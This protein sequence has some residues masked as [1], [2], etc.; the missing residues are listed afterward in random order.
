MA[1]PATYRPAP[2]SIPTGPGVYRFS[3]ADG[4]VLYV[5]KAKNLRQRLNSYFAD[6][7]G[8]HFRTQTMVRTAA[9]VEWTVV[10]NELESLQL[11]YTWIK[12]F[13]PRFN[14]KY[15]DDKSY[16]WVAVTWS[17]DFPRVF[18]GR[19][20]RRRGTR[21]FGPYAHAWAIRDTIDS[22]LRV[23]PMRSCTGGVF[24]GA[25]AA[26]RPC[27]LGYIGKCSAPCV[28]RI[29][30]D[31]HRLLVEDLCAFLA[32]NTGG[33][34]RRLER[35]MAAASAALEFERAAVLRDQLG[36]LR[37]VAERNAIVLGDGTDADVISYAADELEI[38]FQIFH[39]RGGRVRG[40]RGWVADR[41]DDQTIPELLDSF[42]LELYADT[43]DSTEVG[44]AIPREVLLPVRPASADALAALL[45]DV[46]GARVDLR[47]PKRGD[48]R[49]L[50][51]TVA[52][53]AADALALHKTRRASDLSTRNRALEEIQEAL[54]LPT[55]PL[56]LECYDISHL[57]GT[58]VVGSM[59]VFEDGLPRKSEYRSFLIRTVEGSNDVGALHEVLTR[60]FRR[61]LEDRAAAQGEQAML[62]DP[63]TGVARRFA[64]APGLVV[65][66]GGA[67]QVA[68]AQAALD[69]LGITGVALVGLA[70]RLEE[71]WLPGEEFPVIMPRSSEG[72]FL[73][74]RARDEAHRFAITRHRSRRSRS[75]V[76]SLLDDVPGLGELRRKALLKHFGSLKK[77]RAARWEDIAQ[78]PGIGPKTALAIKAALDAQAPAEALDAA[79]GELV[80]AD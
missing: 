60:R 64:Y 79:T 56:R 8:L 14:I 52:A 34:V 51:D 42:L 46:R 48:K 70:K 66:D 69:A 3:D 27:L 6:P 75:M 65:V 21:Y 30:E 80:P 1:D 7:A 5:G 58:E 41:I 19:G 36:A 74:Q 68:A 22:L 54:G 23:F 61:H 47:V 25:K 44:R 35:Q 40:E 12:Q 72:L 24:R 50:L 63:V 13:D 76:E 33:I 32:G 29:S 77:L 10:Q 4:V 59:V 62:V 16:P 67:P 17:E 45:A 2:G 78:A 57:Q 53:N 15:R 31:D 73:L 26:G 9:R 28:G 49:T 11:E 55:P 18:V 37:Q 38:A 43:A 39:V 71:L 20:S